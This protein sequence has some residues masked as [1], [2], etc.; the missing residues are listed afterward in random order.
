MEQEDWLMRQIKQLARVLGKMLA[1]MLGIKSMGQAGERLAIANEALRS[2]LD[3]DVDKMLEIPTSEFIET[4][5]RDARWN[6]DNLETLA[7][8]FVLIAEGPDRKGKL[9]EM[10]SKLYEKVLAI[11]EYLDVASSTYSLERG[12]KIE[13]ISKIVRQ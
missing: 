9:A 5:R 13:E 1:D 11:Y 12:R 4:I 3:L 8:I 10:Q 7:D 2:E 6:F